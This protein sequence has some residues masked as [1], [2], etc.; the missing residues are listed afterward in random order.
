MSKCESGAG[1]PAWLI[2]TLAERASETATLA[3]RKPRW[4]M[5][6]LRERGTCEQCASAPAVT[7]WAD[8]GWEICRACC[9]ARID[10][11]AGRF[12]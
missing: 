1:K 7:T 10:A 6:M 12:A 9:D 3:P 11:A 2:V 4:L 8:N 5:D